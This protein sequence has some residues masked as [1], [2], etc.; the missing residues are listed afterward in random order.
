M[1]ILQ[2]YYEN[3]ISFVDDKCET[4]LI[5]S[6]FY[7]GYNINRDKLFNILKY[8]YKFNAT[9]DPCSYTCIQCKYNKSLS[10]MIFRTG[11]VLIVG[12]SSDKELYEVYEMLKRILIDKYL[13]ICENSD[14][15]I[16][17]HEGATKQIKIKK[18]DYLHI[19][20]VNILIYL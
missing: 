13:E 16:I 7:T 8:D 12:K 4:V 10:F 6:N 14:I 3:E 2:P 15:P 1:N 5:N 11:S 18:K 20:E 9:Y 17:E 19:V